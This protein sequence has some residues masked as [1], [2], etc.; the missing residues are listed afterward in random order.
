MR[1]EF[2]AMS[3]RGTIGTVTGTNAPTGIIMSKG[4]GATRPSEGKDPNDDLPMKKECKKS[5][6]VRCTYAN[7][8]KKVKF[9]KLCDGNSLSLN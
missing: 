3:V 9:K 4:W 2:S 5:C 1:C 7:I 8:L 6:D